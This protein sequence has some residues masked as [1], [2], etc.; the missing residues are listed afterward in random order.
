[1][2]SDLRLNKKN[3]WKRSRH[4]NVDLSYADN[5][6]SPMKQVYLCQ[7]VDSCIST[8]GAVVGQGGHLGQQQVAM[9]FTPRCVVLRAPCKALGVS[10]YLARYWGHLSKGLG[11][12]RSFQGI[13]NNFGDWG[14]TQN[15]A[16][17]PRAGVSREHRVEGPL[18]VLFNPWLS[19][20]PTHM[21]R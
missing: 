16:P 8:C 13:I 21:P 3:T 6:C 7:G 2:D 11:A 14:L 5:I 20:D 10:L 9:I 17:I 15:L 4:C 1:M 18:Y 19:E 12:L